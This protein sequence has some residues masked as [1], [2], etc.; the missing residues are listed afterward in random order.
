MTYHRITRHLRDLVCLFHKDQRGNVLMILGLSIIPLT[1][2]VG[3]SVDYSRAMKLQTRLNAAADAAALAAVTQTMMTQTNAQAC[4]TARNMFQGQTSGLN[5]LVL[6]M[7]DP[8]QFKVTLKDNSG[9]ID[10]ASNSSSLNTA[11]AFG[12]TATVS[13]SAHSQNAFGPVLG[14]MT[15]PI[16]GSSQSFAAVAPNIDFYMMLDTSQSM[17]LPATTT[18][19]NA[20]TSATW[21]QNP[22]DSSHGCAFACHQSETRPYSSTASN[23]STLARDIMNNPIDP[24]DTT[25]APKGSQKDTRRRIDN[26]TIARNLGIVLR[27][28]LLTQAISDLTGVA[29]TS[30]TSNHATYRMG[31]TSFDYQFQKIWPTTGNTSNKSTYYVDSDL[32]NVKSHVSNAQAPIYC[33][34]NQRICGTSDNDQNTKFNAAFKGILSTMP[35]AA[36]DGTKT[37]NPQAILF[38]ITDGMWD[39]S[40]PGSNPEGPIY[41]K[42][43]NGNYV[44]DTSSAP[45]LQFCSDVKARNIRIAILYT[46]Y[47]PGSAS[48]QWSKDHVL[49]PYLSSSDQVATALEKCASPG[50]YYKVTTD[51]DISGALAQLFQSAVSTARITQ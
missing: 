42:L 34:N 49:T 2:A 20:M 32:D 41:S 14:M 46:Q 29:K 13:Y 12:R 6:N 19:L 21:G 43:S 3:M 38:L 47:L 37:G 28:D 39:E 45:G 25:P 11:A 48:D 36:G 30:A 33:I 31:L 23:A 35:T 26:Y 4:T 17:L 50:L 9:V 7:A 5:G 8:T 1:F 40:R 22:D 15:L 16:S 44:K 18:G 24:T 27:A 10:C 51:D